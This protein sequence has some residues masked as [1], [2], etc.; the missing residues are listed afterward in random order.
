V[1]PESGCGK[2]NRIEHCLPG[3]VTCKDASKSECTKCNPQRAYTTPDG[4]CEPC[5]EKALPNEENCA[6]YKCKEDGVFECTRCKDKYYARRRQDDAVRPVDCILCR[7]GTCNPSPDS[8][9]F[10]ENRISVVE[11]TIHKAGVPHDIQGLTYTPLPLG[12]GDA[13]RANVYDGQ[14]RA[15]SC[16][17]LI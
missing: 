4:Q 3:E 8:C 15:V 11:G 16:C 12:F 1:D 10:N 13:A 5:P 2:C 9:P 17:G 14:F 7:K 6:E